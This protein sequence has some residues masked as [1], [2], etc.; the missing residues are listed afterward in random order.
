MDCLW[1]VCRKYFGLSSEATRDSSHSC[2]VLL[3]SVFF[4]LGVTQLSHYFEMAWSKYC[5][6]TAAN[7]PGLIHSAC[8]PTGHT[9][10][11]TH[12]AN[13]LA[14]GPL[15]D[16]GWS[17]LG[18]SSSRI[19]L[20]WPACKAPWE[21]KS[22]G[23]LVSSRGIKHSSQCRAKQ[24]QSSPTVGSIAQRAAATTLFSSSEQCWIPLLQTWFWRIQMWKWLSLR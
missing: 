9:P 24:L 8:S 10:W 2:W 17:N 21:A 11:L 23:Q 20:F 22:L 12:H 5:W 19:S 1:V 3:K 15:S 6:I 4:K 13:A 7:F 14:D 16:I 18:I